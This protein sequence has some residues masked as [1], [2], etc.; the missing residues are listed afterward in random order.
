[1]TSAGAATLG[2]KRVVVSAAEPGT[3][4]MLFETVTVGAKRVIARLAATGTTSLLSLTVT[5]GANRLVASDAVPGVTET[6]STW[7]MSVGT[8]SL[9]TAKS[10]EVMRNWIESPPETAAPT[11]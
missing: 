7:V 5:V 9:V 2:A 4:R 8:T 10:G 3:T 6:P 1:M 11:I